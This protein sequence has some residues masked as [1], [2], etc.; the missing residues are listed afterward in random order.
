VREPVDIR[1]ARQ[2]QERIDTESANRPPPTDRGNQAVTTESGSRPQMPAGE[3]RP[4][5]T[6]DMA[7]STA[8]TDGTQRPHEDG[9]RR[10]TVQGPTDHSSPT[11]LFRADEAGSFRTKWESVQTAFVDDP[12]HA[13]EDADH[14][15]AEAIQRLASVFADERTNLEHQWNGGGD[16]ST[17]DLRLALQKYRSFFERLLAA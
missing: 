1:N 14:L 12:R 17:E 13:V 6:A 8:A 7:R 4:L 9:E 11:P 10:A 3:K 2:E 5:T 16:A 15:V